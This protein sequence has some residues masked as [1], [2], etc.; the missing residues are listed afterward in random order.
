LNRQVFLRP[1]L[2][3]HRKPRFHFEDRSHKCT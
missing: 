1:Q 2:V 3:R